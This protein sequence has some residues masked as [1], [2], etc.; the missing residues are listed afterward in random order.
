MGV[1]KLR[2]FGPPA[3]VFFGWFQGFGPQEAH[4]HEDTQNTWLKVVFTRTSE[5]EICRSLTA[6]SSFSG[7]C[8]YG[9]SDPKGT[10]IHPKQG[11]NRE[12]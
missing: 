2:Y 9:L 4:R 8:H 7:Q 5:V 10:L 12:F 3:I 11:P 1:D 6:M